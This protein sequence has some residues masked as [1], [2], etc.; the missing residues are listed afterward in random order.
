MNKAV[1]DLL[2]DETQVLKASMIESQTLILPKA[3]F[4]QPRELP[5][6]DNDATLIIPKNK[7]II[8]SNLN[9]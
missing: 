9:P 1:S 5:E 7:S 6:D 3:G 2:S 4:Q 8:N